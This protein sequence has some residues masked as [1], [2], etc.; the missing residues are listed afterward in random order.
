MLLSSFWKCLV[1]ISFIFHLLKFL[2]LFILCNLILAPHCL[3][4]FV[5]G[6][7]NTSIKLVTLLSMT[8]SRY[9]IL[10][11]TFRRSCRKVNDIIFLI[12]R[13]L[14]QLI[15]LIWSKAIFRILFLI[16]YVLLLFQ[17]SSSLGFQFWKSIIIIVF[18][19]ICLLVIFN[20][21]WPRFWCVSIR[22]NGWEAT[23][24]TVRFEIL[25]N[26]TLYFTWPSCS[27]VTYS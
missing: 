23:A 9:Y 24:Q 6:L 13:W 26:L 4:I 14:Y 2:V 25:M 19:L 11:A 27:S 21:L 10:I 7:I 18:K 3:E 16:N 8:F 1:H 12:I 22:S 5:L 17:C 15:W 20:K